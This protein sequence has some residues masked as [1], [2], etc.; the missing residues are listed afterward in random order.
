MLTKQDL[1]TEFKNSGGRWR[2]GTNDYTMFLERKILESDSL[3]KST[4]GKRFPFST[5][6]VGQSFDAGEYSKSLKNTIGDC[7]FRLNKTTKGKFTQNKVDNR[8]IVKR[9]K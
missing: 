4:I 6:L 7:I 1:R 3:I 8:L 9:I 2:D 5:L